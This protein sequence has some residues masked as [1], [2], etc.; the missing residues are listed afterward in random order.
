MKTCGP[1]ALN[2]VNVEAWVGNACTVRFPLFA[3]FIR[4]QLSGIE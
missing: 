1:M 4:E 3:L 2:S